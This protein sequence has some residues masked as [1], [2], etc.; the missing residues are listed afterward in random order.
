MT[1]NTPY[2]R[3]FVPDQHQLNYRV[4]VII[5]LAGLVIIS[6]IAYT[7]LSRNVTIDQITDPHLQEHLQQSQTLS[8]WTMLLTI[9]VFIVYGYMVISGNN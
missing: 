1:D 9:F 6:S 8:L 3:G 7:N 5:V 2:L 4:F